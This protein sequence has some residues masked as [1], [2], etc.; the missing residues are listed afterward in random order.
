MLLYKK[1]EVCGNK[2][3]KLQ[4]VW[5]LYAL[6]TGEVIQCSHCGTYYKTSKTIQ[7][8]A[9]LYENLGLGVVLWFILGIFMNI[10]IHMLHIDF[11]KNISFILSLV[12]SFL[13]LGFINCIIAC[14]I[15]LYTT[16]VHTQKR[17]N[18]LCIG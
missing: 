11:N 16:Q 9:S 6:K 13:L 10:L 15:P 2:I 3:N 17:K 8:I 1:C 5:N 14:I 12:L 4:N 18:H 7:A